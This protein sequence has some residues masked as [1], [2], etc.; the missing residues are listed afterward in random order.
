MSFVQT[1]S[2]LNKGFSTL[3]EGLKNFDLTV[4]SLSQDIQKLEKKVNDLKGNI[5]DN[6]LSLE[7]CT[8]FDSTKIMIQILNI[9]TV[10]L[11]PVL[12]DP[13][14]KITRIVLELFVY[15]FNQ[16][17]EKI[18][19]REIDEVRKSIEQ[20]ANKS[21]INEEIQNEFNLMKKL[22]EPEKITK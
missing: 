3:L 12:R 18:E 15:Q 4:V 14:I 2:A 21:K 16:S 8:F 10:L 7:G 1:G 22:L 9:K 20:L 13:I 17:K 19:Q 6:K 11:L 5:F